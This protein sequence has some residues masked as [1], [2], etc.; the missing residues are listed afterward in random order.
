MIFKA[1][2][3]WTKSQDECRIERKNDVKN[4]FR[5]DHSDA[6]RP[7]MVKLRRGASATGNVQFRPFPS[8]D[9]RGGKQ[10]FAAT[11]ILKFASEEAVVET[12]PNIW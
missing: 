9:T 11:A 12:Q 4:N 1:K 6:R 2:K 10:K 3:Y 8:I 7:G 5:F